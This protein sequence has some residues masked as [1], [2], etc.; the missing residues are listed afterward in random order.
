MRY[1]PDFS[2]RFRIL[3]GGKI[4][5]VVS[6][7]LVGSSMSYASPSGGTVTTG[8][9]T[10]NQSGTVTT[11]N[12]S[13][14]KASINWQSFSIAPSET[15]NFVQPSASSVTLNRVVGA[16]QSLIEGAMNAN[17]QVFLINPNGVVFAQGSQVNVGGIVASTLNI[18]DADFQAGNYVFEGNSQN[19]I[20]NMG[21]ITTAQGGYVAL[22]GK[23]V[24]NQGT[25]VA[26]MGN[27]QLAAGDK[28][29][30][31]LNGN[32]LLGLSIDQGT[33]NALVENGGLIKADGGQVYLTTQALDSILDGMVNNTGIIEAQNLNNVDGK[34][35]LFAHGG[36]ANVGGTIKAEGGFVETSGTHIN[37][38]DDLHIKVKTWLIDPYN[39]EIVSD[40][41]AE[42]N[43]IYNSYGTINPQSDTSTI[44]AS[45]LQN[46]LA[47]GDVYLQTGWSGSQNGDLTVKSAISWSSGQDLYL[48]AAGN[49]YVNADITA[50]NA[51]AKLTLEYGQGAVAAGNTSDYYIA[52]GSKISL[53]DGQNFSTKLGS[54][55]T[56]VN[57]TVVNS[58]TALQAI[59][60]NLSGNYALGSDVDLTGV[61]WTSIGDG[62]NPFVG[63]FDGLGH[64]VSNL[65]MTSNNTSSMGL[66]GAAFGA[67]L[68]NIGVVNVNLTGTGTSDMIG[69]LV[70]DAEHNMDSGDPIVIK[71]VYSSGSISGR[72]YVGG[73]IGYL[74]HGVVLNSDSSVAITANQKAGGLIGGVDGLSI[75]IKSIVMNSFA[76][77]NVTSTSGTAGGLVGTSWAGDYSNSYASGNVNGT[78]NEIGGFIGYM[79]SS[80]VR[81]AYAIGSVTG[82]NNV[83]GF[84][85]VIYGGSSLTNVWASGDVSV[86][87]EG[88]VGGL[89]G[90][91]DTSGGVNTVTNGYWDKTTTGQNFSASGLSGQTGINNSDAYTQSTY[92]GFDF[93]NDWFMVDGY[94]R[95]FL[96]MEWTPVISNAHQLQM[97]SLKLGSS[98]TPIYILANN[99]DL[100]P[101]LT[102]KSDMWKD[103]SSSVDYNNYQGSFVPVGAGAEVDGSDIFFGSFDGQN[104]TIDN[105]YIYRPLDFYVGLFGSVKN[106]TFKNLTLSNVDITAYEEVGALV[107]I[108]GGADDSLIQNVTSSGV[109]NLNNNTQ[110]GFIDASYAGGLVGETSVTTLIDNSS[111]SVNIYANSGADASYYIG[112]LVGANNGEITNSFATGTIIAGDDGSDIGGLVGDNYGTIS[113]SY[114]TGNITV[115][116]Q[117]D[118]DSEIGGFAGYNSG[119]IIDS[120]STGNVV[121]GSEGY[122]VGGFVGYNDSSEGSGN[123]SG[124]YA[125]GSVTVGTVNAE[126]SIYGGY[127]VGGFAGYN[128]ST[129]VG[130]HAT[131]EVISGDYSEYVGGFVGYTESDI[132]DAYA[133]GAVTVGNTSNDIGGFAGNLYGASLDR[134][135]ATGNVTTG[136]ASYNI[137]GLV[138]NL[139]G[140]GG[141]TIINESYATG[142][143]GV[144]SEGDYT[145]YVGGL[146]G[147]MEYGEIHKSFATGDVVGG[148]GVGGFLGYA[149]YAGII[150]D[151]FA[152]GSVSGTTQIGGFIGDAYDGIDEIQRN[153]ATGSVSGTSSYVAGFAGR[154]YPGSNENPYQYFGAANNFWDAAT[155]GQTVAFY[156]HGGEGTPVSSTAGIVSSDT[157]AMLKDLATYSNAS[158]NIVNDPSLSNVYPKLRWATTG[159]SAGESVWVIGTYAPPSGG[160]EGGSSSQEEQ[161]VNDVVTTIVNQASVVP[162]R[163]PTFT[164]PTA[165]NTA[166]QEAGRA[167]VN[168][169]YPGQDLGLVSSPNGEQPVRAIESNELLAL[170]ASKGMNELRVPL[171]NDSMVDLVNGGLNLPKGVNQEFY[172]VSNSDSTQGNGN[173][174]AGS[175]KDD[176][177][178]QQN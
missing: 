91:N 55:G 29:T 176:K 56:T 6:A 28:M 20:L 145:Y 40:A 7:L 134:V 13:S 144:S 52:R 128:D 10:I 3:K 97:M 22:M 147:Y 174:K 114:A 69:A 70:G 30:L 129:I 11:I 67:T 2:S 170:A 60:S 12:Q 86:T 76:T 35:V 17:G 51:A 142:N 75:E 131:G 25:I 61:T 163:I 77:G 100:A 54:D 1:A 116:D 5:L 66:F 78:G 161:T 74:Y 109:I 137:G 149:S 148:E 155:T 26:T 118:Y 115:G 36:T 133:T 102:N 32:S 92:S 138:G 157:T 21:T 126:D 71:N 98:N 23:T 120:H 159:L 124:S 168:A 16:T 112:G 172:V 94:T 58:A 83:G 9:A 64:K 88:N 127:Y 178:T 95:P 164:P 89:V 53:K 136:D 167:L 162:P 175:D 122:Y 108:I 143:V 68:Q 84:L 48:Q 113:N 82:A 107:G 166:G 31:N 117:T 39:L 105:L 44:K 110:D 46:A 171:G 63:K 165:S 123:I 151:N 15:V 42:S 34:I 152:T 62:Y 96:K 121:V 27:A 72:Y 141:V 156:W 8:S 85:G 37:F 79:G 104:H 101:S 111:S 81:D 45:T 160:G 87:A 158:W 177:K 24:Q 33:I 19:G 103:L 43:D 57:Y 130:S 73:L 50:T 106:A 65:T 132:S 140:S 139:A 146:V 14:N 49:L 38:S 169:I 80:S 153:Y 90:R 47:T 154:V 59:N 4:S 135:Y 119:T 18:T 150:N 93:I 41:E 99:I 125:A 173:N